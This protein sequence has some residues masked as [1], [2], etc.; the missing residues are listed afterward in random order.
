MYQS[1]ITLK[2]ISIL[3]GYSVST[4][5]KALNG[6]SD[7]S[8]KTKEIIKNI[9]IEHNYV[10]NFSALS[11]RKQRT[12]TFAIIV[13]EIADAC[14]GGIISDIQKMSF[15]QGY[16][17]LVF[18]SFSSEEQEE[19]CLKNINDGSVDAA[20]MISNFKQDNASIFI[21]NQLPIE[22]ID[23]SNLQNKKGLKEQVII[24]FKKSLKQLIS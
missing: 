11:L 21:N 18:Q 20:I 16:R 10:P 7:I 12:R 1:T 3:S 15:K 13:P 8:S 14:Y 23:I 9:A 24:S 19:Q 17:L 2:S 5:S 4:V 6:K 22:Y